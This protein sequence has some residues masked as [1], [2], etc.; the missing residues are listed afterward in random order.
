MR[1]TE[2][3]RRYPSLETRLKVSQAAGDS[4][5]KAL[6]RAFQAAG[7]SEVITF[8]SAMAAIGV[9][10]LARKGGTHGKA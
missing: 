3:T 6:A 7:L 5:N 2:V 1:S 8:T 4:T 10:P 9:K